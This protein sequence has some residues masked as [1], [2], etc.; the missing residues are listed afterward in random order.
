[1]NGVWSR[2]VALMFSC[3]CS[4]YLKTRSSLAS[5]HMRT[6]IVSFG[7]LFQRSAAIWLARFQTSW[8]MTKVS[9]VTSA[10]FNAMSHTCCLCCCMTWVV[11]KF[12]H[13]RLFSSSF[14]YAYKVVPNA[15]RKP[16][17]LAPWHLSPFL[18]ACVV[19]LYIS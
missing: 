14:F 12:C 10:F 18:F 16:A 19:S 3:P 15:C 6:L 4:W 8:G 17:T 13:K 11:V 2:S 9:R 7:C 1:M 5:F